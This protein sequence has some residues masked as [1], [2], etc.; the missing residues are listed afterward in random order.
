MQAKPSLATFYL[1]T[2]TSGTPQAALTSLFQQAGFNPVDYQLPQGYLLPSAQ[3]LK[4]QA[5]TPAFTWLDNTQT[6]DLTA[7]LED[8]QDTHVFLFY[9]RPEAFLQAALAE[10]KTPQQALHAWQTQAKELLQTYR[11]HRSRTSLLMAEACLN[12]P[13]ESLAQLS[14]K[15]GWS[16]HERNFTTQSFQLEE[17][18]ELLLA[19]QLITQTPEVRQLLSEL[20]AS[21][22]NPAR[23]LQPLTLDL[24]QI[25]D[26]SPVKHLQE[27]LKRQQE[28]QR[29]E[30]SD[31]QNKIKLAE[32]K[33]NKQTQQPDLE[34]ENKL[35]IEQLHQVQEELERHHQNKNQLPAR[36]SELNQLER[37][38]RQV[39]ME[40]A[41]LQEKYQAV[42]RSN[43][44]KITKPLRALSRLLKGK[45]LRAKAG[46]GGGS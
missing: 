8:F 43:S 33:T 32:E 41:R 4:N 1:A 46:Q 42:F 31:L 39:Q 23:L 25:I 45:P 18:Q 17:N 21:S 11:S 34:E 28:Q 24:Q 22:S 37:K 16:L 13:Q 6:K 44:W 15:L 5:P 27:E 12:K 38:L 3:G 14:D 40:K 36:Q 20:E 7:W 10:G 19:S 29:K 2:S 35:L 9:T 30:I 26:R